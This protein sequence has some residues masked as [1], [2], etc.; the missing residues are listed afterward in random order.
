M[1]PKFGTN[2]PSF[3]ADG[4]QTAPAASTVLASTGQLA[5]GFYKVLAGCGYGATADVIDN[6][7]LFVAD[8]R[9]ITLPV[10][11]VANSNVQFVTIDRVLVK[12]GEAITVQNLAAGGAG[13]VF[14]GTVVATRLED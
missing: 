14:R 1:A 10:I 4:T 11:P 12:E 5:A 3:A 13:S 2:T 8:R 7:A 9:V 6:A